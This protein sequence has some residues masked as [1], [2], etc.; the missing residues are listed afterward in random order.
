M[1]RSE[2]GPAAARAVI[3]KTFSPRE[4][5]GLK[6]RA[7][8]GAVL[9]VAPGSQGD[10]LGIQAGWTIVRV[11]GHNFSK[12]RMDSVASGTDDFVISFV[13]AK[14]ER[15]TSPT[16]TTQAVASTTYG[17]LPVKR[18][19]EAFL[20]KLSQWGSTHSTFLGTWMALLPIVAPL[21]SIFWETSSSTPVI[22]RCNWHFPGPTPQRLFC[23]VTYVA[24]H[25]FPAL[26]SFLAIGLISWRFVRIRLFYVLL[27][28]KVNIEMDAGRNFALYVSGAQVLLFLLSC[29]HLCLTFAYGYG[30]SNDVMDEHG[31]FAKRKDRPMLQVPL[32]D[33]L[34]HPNLLYAEEHQELLET[35]KHMIKAFLVPSIVAIT[36]TYSIIRTDDTIPLREALEASAEPYYFHQH[37][38]ETITVKEDV[39]REILAHDE[40]REGPS[41]SS[42]VMSLIEDQEVD[43]ACET[44]RRE[45]LTYS[46]AF[47]IG[48]HPDLERFAPKAA[49]LP[50]PGFWDIVIDGIPAWPL[51]IILK[52]DVSEHDPIPFSYS[53][54]L[55]CGL[56]VTF[57]FTQVCLMMWC[58]YHGP[59]H[60][61]YANRGLCWDSWVLMAAAMIPVLVLEVKSMVKI[62]KLMYTTKWWE[63]DLSY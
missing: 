2:E 34:S 54:L 30:S 62:V 32:A 23:D 61:L 11:N 10:V 45:A 38:G 29:M 8:T 37:V 31:L 20:A 33:M 35:T 40:E 14:K 47:Q 48:V 36:F 22:I 5:L 56:C 42:A 44:F 55:H 21:T 53:L 24:V 41:F 50:Q 28:R 60:A 17:S 18:K 1:M 19:A 57:L 12:A 16:R 7:D 6:F 59:Y 9:S 3:D 63:G 15:F 26:S 25:V 46:G 49:S 4:K 39:A 43:G 58:L 27:K 13:R 52:R 51:K